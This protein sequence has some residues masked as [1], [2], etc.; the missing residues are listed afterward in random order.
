MATNLIAIEDAIVAKLQPLVAT[1]NV[2]IGK[3]DANELN[4][5][6]QSHQI[7]VDY[8][9]FK[10]ESPM[11]FNGQELRT[12]SYK[13]YVRFLNLQTHDLAYPLLGAIAKLL[14]DFK[15]LANFT[16]RPMRLLSEKPDTSQ[17]KDGLW[18]YVQIYEFQILEV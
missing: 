9:G 18:F 6:V 16:V 5:P 12:Y 2:A 3:L 1:Y 17:V 4:R 15:P 8:D 11:S 7:F 10:S 13:I 14:K